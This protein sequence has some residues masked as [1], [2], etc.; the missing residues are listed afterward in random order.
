[1]TTTHTLKTA[2]SKAVNEKL[3]VA[4]RNASTGAFVRISDPAIK[5][6]VERLKK[7]LSKDPVA[8]RRFM[9]RVGYLTPKGN[10]A[11]RYA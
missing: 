5:P 9:E 3:H 8:A 10:I 2:P 11:A 7:E 1:M 6:R 4:G